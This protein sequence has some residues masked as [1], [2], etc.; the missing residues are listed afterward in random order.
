M[1]INWSPFLQGRSGMDLSRSL[2]SASPVTPAGDPAS[3]S[4]HPR[5][6]VAGGPRPPGRSRRNRFR[7]P[8][9]SLLA[10]R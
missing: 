5:P 8:L 3:S 9:V 6:H 10:R 4:S 1:T 2:P 7:L